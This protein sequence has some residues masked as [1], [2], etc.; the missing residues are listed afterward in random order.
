MKTHLRIL[1]LKTELLHPVD[2]GGKIR[3]FHMLKELKREHHITYLT[4]DDGSGAPDAEERAT[5][6]CHELVRV[7]HRTR[8]KF[9]AGFYGELAANLVSPLPYFMKKYKSAGMRREIERLAASGQ[10]DVLVC[11]FLQP[12]VNLPPRLPLAT[13]LFQHNV[14]A[15]IWKRH[16]EVQ[17]NPLKKSYLYG[18]WRKSHAYERAACR[19]FDHVV[20]VSA[21]DRETMERAYG[22]KSVSDVPTGVD[23]EFFRPRGEERREPH[24]LVFTGSMDWLPNE[25]AIQFFTREIMPRIRERVPGA[26]LTVVGRNPYASLVELGKRDSSIIVTGRV[27]DVRPY[28]ERAAAYIVPM[29]VG[30]GTRLKIYEAMAMEKPIVSTTVGAEGLPVANGRELL[31]A[32]TAKDFAASVVRVL[33]DE[34]EARELGARAAVAVREKFSWDKVSEAFAE[35]CGRAVATHATAGA[36]AGAALENPIRGRG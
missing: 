29:R 20:A 5:E 34:A 8:A 6:Y 23:T 32:D 16:Y 27:E 3:T 1:W 13:V 18:Q 35:A 36:A 14:E 10:F 33:T 19:R 28:M 21:E 22:L 2:K 4:L 24:N 9:S 7:E 17:T 15:M 30:G 12:G 31:L 25:D 11:D 26:T